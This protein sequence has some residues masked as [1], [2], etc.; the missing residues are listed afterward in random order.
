MLIGS[1]IVPAAAQG[2]APPALVI[3]GHYGIPVIIDGIDATGAVIYGEMGLSRPGHGRIVIEGGVPIP[4]GPVPPRFF[5]AT[6]RPPTY[7]AEHVSVPVER[8]SRPAD[9][10]RS[11]SSS[12]DDLPA[13]VTPNYQLPAGDGASQQDATPRDQHRHGRR[14]R[15]EPHRSSHA[16]ESR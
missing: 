9:F 16:W 1:G 5:P 10:H 12:S 8:S 2:D 14:D 11:W 3:P 15:I 13:T 6:G 7:G 4:P